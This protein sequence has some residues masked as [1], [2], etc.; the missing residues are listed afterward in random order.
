MRLRHMIDAAEAVASFI[1]GRDRPDLATDR[2]LLFAVVRA[3]E[4]L[5]EAAARTSPETRAEAPDV[6][7][8]AIVGMRN[9]LIHG[10]F[11]V[12]ADI[13]WQTATAELP[14]LLPRLK[15]LLGP[16]NPEAR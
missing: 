13:V 1:A 16:Q 11:D 9:R 12:D 8:S 3:V 2:M 5:G 4:V 14:D 7:W 10:Y 15:R 6:P